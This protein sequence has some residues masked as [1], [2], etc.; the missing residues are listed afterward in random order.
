MNVRFTSGLHDLGEEED[1]ADRN[2]DQDV[3]RIN[4]VSASMCR[5]SSKSMPATSL[6][7]Q[8]LVGQRRNGESYACLAYPSLYLR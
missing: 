7:G 4:S 6:V 2:D 5:L 8:S 1:G 3:S